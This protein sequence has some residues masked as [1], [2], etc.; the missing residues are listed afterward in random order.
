MEKLKILLAEDH[1]ILRE[2]LRR[3]IDD[4]PNMQV[5]GEADDGVT[6]WQK[7]KELEPDVVLMDLSMPRLKRR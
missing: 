3:L 7:T 1:R 2:G 5:V 6:A 4:A